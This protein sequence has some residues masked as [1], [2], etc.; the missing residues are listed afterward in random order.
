MP[1]K[2]GSDSLRLFPA[3]P[4]QIVFLNVETRIQADSNEVAGC[5]KSEG[6]EAVVRTDNPYE[7]LFSANRVST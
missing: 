2:G 5:K 1:N 7:S 4:F 3:F 6:I